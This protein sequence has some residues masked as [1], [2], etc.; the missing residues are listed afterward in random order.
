[1]FTK[2]K[3]V[4]NI[5]RITRYHVQPLLWDYITFDL[6]SVHKAGAET[7]PDQDSALK[8][9]LGVIPEM[10]HKTGHHSP[11]S[12]RVMHHAWTALLF[13]SRGTNRSNDSRWQRYKSTK[14]KQINCITIVACSALNKINFFFRRREISEAHSALRKHSNISAITTNLV[15]QQRPQWV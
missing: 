3:Y 9:K 8:L 4:S 5:K 1:M 10:K 12:V 11:F 15:Q 2:H 14:R 13:N 7:S 6:S